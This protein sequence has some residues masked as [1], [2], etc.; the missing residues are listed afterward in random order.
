MPFLRLPRFSKL[1][2]QYLLLRLTILHNKSNI[3]QRLCMKLKVNSFVFFSG[4]GAKIIRLS[5]PSPLAFQTESACWLQ[6]A[7]IS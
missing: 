3:L 2:Q 5:D 1:M 4:V 6:K 7:K